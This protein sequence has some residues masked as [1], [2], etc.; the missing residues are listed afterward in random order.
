MAKYS[1]LITCFLLIFYTFIL[2]FLPYKRI[3]PIH[4]QQSKFLVA[5]NYLFSKNKKV[6]TVIVGSSMSAM[7]NVKYLPQSVINLAISGDMSQTGINLIKMS[8]RLP[9]KLFVE[10]N[11]LNRNED[12]TL[13]NAFTKNFQGKLKSIF[14][15]LQERNQFLTVQMNGLDYI[16]KVV[17]KT[18]K[19][20]PT[21]PANEKILEKTQADYKAIENDTSEFNNVKKNIAYL[22]STFQEF[23]RKGVKI[24]LFRMPFEK[25]TQKVL[26]KSKRFIFEKNLIEKELS[27]IPNVKMIPPDTLHDYHTTDGT[28]LTKDD[29]QFF[30]IYLLYFNGK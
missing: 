11:V 10:L 24:Y 3:I 30:A 29:A 12:S 28:H 18:L 6:E 16:N 13:L 19:A 2:G 26:E 4:V 22:K 9:E 7:L 20:N 14:P 15:F 23:T 8:G 27:N 1:I 17:L 25:S 5:E 21:Y